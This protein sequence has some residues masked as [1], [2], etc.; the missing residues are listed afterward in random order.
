MSKFPLN[1]RYRQNLAQEDPVYAGTVSPSRAG[2]R[3]DPEERTGKASVAQSELA[4]LKCLRLRTS[5]P[6]QRKVEAH[7]CYPF[8]S[9]CH[10]IS[11]SGELPLQNPYEIVS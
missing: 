2:S 7:L 3:G 4:G 5:T 10:Q 11:L 1:S 8:S 6:G 9:S